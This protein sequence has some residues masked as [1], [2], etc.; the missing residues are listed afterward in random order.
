MI[1]DLGAFVL[2]YGIVPALLV[3]LAA[4]LLVAAVIEVVGAIRERRMRARISAEVRKAVEA[5]VDR[6][7]PPQRGPGE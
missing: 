1:R 3:V 4:W 6:L 7:V 2:G 5:N